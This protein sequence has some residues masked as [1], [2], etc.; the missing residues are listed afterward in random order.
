MKPRRT[1]LGRR[2]APN[3]SG[4]YLIG[5]PA[6]PRQPWRSALDYALYYRCP[7]CAEVWAIEKPAGRSRQP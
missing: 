6:D 7:R 5:L 3:V 1:L 2:H 4:D